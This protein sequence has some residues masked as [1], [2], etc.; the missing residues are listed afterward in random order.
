MVKI[1]EIGFLVMLLTHLLSD[2][3]FQS[4][5]MA[6]GCRKSLK[7]VGSHALVYALG[8]AP[9]LALGFRLKW[10]LVWL[11][12]LMGA[13][14]AVIDGAKFAICRKLRIKGRGK[15]GLA[16]F[17]LD[18]CAHIAVLIALWY[19]LGVR[20]TVRPYLLAKVEYLPV[21]PITLAVA[22]AAILRP[23]GLLIQNCRLW[24]IT[25]PKTE[26]KY[27]SDPDLN[28]G[29]IIGYLE[30]LI[31]LLLVMYGQFSAIAFVLTAKSVARFK[32]IEES[33]ITAE[34]YLIGTLMSAAATLVIAVLLGICGNGA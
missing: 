6:Q 4:D 25:G 16:V 29:R 32:E 27:P 9:I 12:L 30:R 17:L 8:L 24:T 22:V 11:W 2:F 7:G 15:N 33:R 1:L 18:Q 3:Y 23:V 28:T 26:G 31:I 34:Y 13:A 20:L 19:T 5:K 21:L 14:H 10:D